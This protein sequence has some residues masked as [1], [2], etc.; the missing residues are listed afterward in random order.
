MSEVTEHLVSQR[1]IAVVGVSDKK[2]GGAIYRTLK[3]RGYAVYPVHPTRN[4]STVMPAIPA[5]ATCQPM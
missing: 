5:L 4:H 2:F 3:N 1:N